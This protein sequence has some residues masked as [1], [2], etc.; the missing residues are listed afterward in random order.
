MNEGA[1]VAADDVLQDALVQDAVLADA[2]GQDASLDF[3]TSWG[4]QV[5][6]RR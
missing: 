6:Q 4:F 2:V 5:L 1:V 3:L